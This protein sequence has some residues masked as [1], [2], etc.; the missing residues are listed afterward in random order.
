MVEEDCLGC[1]ERAVAY[2]AA[3]HLTYLP[4]QVKEVR[5]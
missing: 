1:K 5:Q 4:R 2:T 3:I